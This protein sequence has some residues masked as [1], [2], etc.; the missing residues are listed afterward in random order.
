M[1]GLRFSTGVLT[2]KSVHPIR[3]REKKQ[4]SPTEGYPAHVS[5]SLARRF[6]V[7]HGN[8]K[9]DLIEKILLD[10][11]RIAFGVDRIVLPMTSD[12]SIRDDFFTCGVA[13]DYLDIRICNEKIFAVR[14]MH[15][16][17]STWSS[18]LG[19]KSEVNSFA[20][21]QC[22]HRLSLVVGKTDF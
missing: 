2:W 3:L 8:E 21:F 17:S 20:Y 18:A 12:R 4:S 14:P 16:C 1:T 6:L 10:I 5:I 19:R 9:G 11:E 22:E 15:S 13:K 7:H